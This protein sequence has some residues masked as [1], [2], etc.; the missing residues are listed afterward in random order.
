ML[1]EY[2]PPAPLKSQKPPFQRSLTVPVFYTI[3]ACFHLLINTRKR[4]ELLCSRL[5]IIS[6]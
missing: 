1:G 6:M 3:A 5:C 2:T 4:L